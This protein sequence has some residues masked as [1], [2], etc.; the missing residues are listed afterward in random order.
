MAQD[1]TLYNGQGSTWQLLLQ[2]VAPGGPGSEH[3]AVERVAEAVGEL[4][5]QATEKER[6]EKAVGE[7]LRNAA[8]REMRD[9][10]HS[11][12]SIRVWI[13]G[14][15][16]AD[17]MTRSGARRAGPQKR[18]G[19]GFFLLERQE[20]GPQAVQADSQRVIELYLYQETALARKGGGRERLEPMQH[21]NGSQE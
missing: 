3:Q 7:A 21:G 6:I 9:P 5:L 10:H 19:W 12:V 11:P 4:G 14:L 2:F 8:Q 18:R 15:S 20:G 13:S 16:I 17:A 1:N